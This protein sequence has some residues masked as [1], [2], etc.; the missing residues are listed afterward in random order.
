MCDRERLREDLRP[1]VEDECIGYL[2]DL[3]GDIASADPALRAPVDRLT[4]L[5][6]AWP[7]VNPR[8]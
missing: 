6:Q 1:E 3:L 4:E 8:P 5:L 2:V 7:T